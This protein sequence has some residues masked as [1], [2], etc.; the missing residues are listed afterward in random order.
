[1]SDFLLGGIVI[2]G[3]SDFAFNYKA[4][5]YDRFRDWSQVA[6]APQGEWTSLPQ[7]ERNV[8]TARLRY[9][10]RNNEYCAALAGTFSTH[11]GN[12]ALRAKSS[13]P[14]YDDQKERLWLEFVDSAEITG[15]SLAE[16]ED[17]VYTELLCAGEAFLLLLSTG[18]VQLIPAE[19]VFSEDGEKSENEIQ[20]I[21]Y[22]GKGVPV[23]YR[24]GQRDKNGRLV[25]GK[26]T[27]PARQ[28]L[29]VYRRDRIEQLRGVPMLAPAVPAIQDL[30]EIVQAK[31][32]GVKVQSFLAAAVTKNGPPS[33]LTAGDPA[34]NGR[35]SRYRTLTSASLMYLEP[36][37]EIKT[38]GPNFQSSDFEQFLL[39]RL[40]AVGAVIGMPIELFIEGYRDSNYSS[41]RA[42]NLAWRSKVQ[43]I[44]ALIERR[45]L[46]PLQLWVSARGR[47]LGRLQGA[48][49]LDRECSF[50]FPPVPSI[51]E[52]KEAQ[53]NVEKLNAGLTTLTDIF[54]EN[55]AFYDD[56]IRVR[57]RDIKTALEAA[58][59]E[60]ID[61]ALLLP[62][63]KAAAPKA[64]GPPTGENQPLAKQENDQI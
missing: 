64:E 26:S 17:V 6:P 13:D 48:P 12:S 53:A 11:L 31:V 46:N 33:P 24:I 51:D 57:A 43:K 39:S 56:Q 28:V 19:W 25:A 5:S 29:H 18:K 14:Q 60:G 1:M 9:L 2:P 8:I 3:G 45:L 34:T 62:G 55:G 63:L 15:L 37:E 7:W 4:A 61:P 21:I 41:A 20:G 32:S 58:E 38:L 42:T 44:R 47:A 27:V 52:L 16:I 35:P 54:A 50:S 30:A 22:D 23:S 10:I 36:G 59:S 40:R 49:S